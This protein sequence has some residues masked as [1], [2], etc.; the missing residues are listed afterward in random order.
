M[1]KIVTII[2]ARPEFIK[3]ATVSRPLAEN[4]WV[5]GSFLYGNRYSSKLLVDF[6]IQKQK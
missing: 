4:N 3:A 6:L 5:K 1:I 2:G